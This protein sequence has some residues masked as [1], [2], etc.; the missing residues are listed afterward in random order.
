LICYYLFFLDILKKEVFLKLKGLPVI[1]YLSVLQC[2]F[3]VLALGYWGSSLRGYEGKS[4]KMLTD[5][6]T[7]VTWNDIISSRV[8]E[9]V[10][11][12]KFETPKDATVVVIPEA[13]GINFFSERVNPLRY[14]VVFPTNLSITPE[15]EI[16]DDFRT[17]NADYIVIVQR[18]T[19][20]YGPTS[21]GVDY[22][23]ELDG[24][25]KEHYSLV[26]K[27]GPLPFTTKEFGIAIYKSNQLF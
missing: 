26:Q 9:A 11:Y 19:I 15:H 3:L 14:P 7:Y 23:L 18:P 24:W 22:A 27:I 20:E 4:M 25:I 13:E 12:L 2:F 17:V 10:A 6:G 16:I 21:F 1:P 5:R 8:W